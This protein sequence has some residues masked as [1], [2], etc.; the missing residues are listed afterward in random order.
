MSIG[1]DKNPNNLLD[2]IQA[3]FIGITCLIIGLW[4]IVERILFSFSG[5]IIDLGKYHTIIGMGFIVFSLVYL[6]LVIKNY[7]KDT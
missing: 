3:L 4:A 5:R 1:G 2:L 6:F 7:S